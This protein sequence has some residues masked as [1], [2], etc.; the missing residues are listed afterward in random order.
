MLGDI[1]KGDVVGYP[2]G[3]FVH[4]A[5]VTDEQI[6]NERRPGKTKVRIFLVY[7]NQHLE[8][9]KSKLQEAPNEEQL[10]PEGV[11]TKLLIRSLDMRDPP[12]W[13]S[14]KV[15]IPL[16]QPLPE[17][18]QIARKVAKDKWRRVS[19]RSRLRRSSSR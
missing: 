18:I 1:S 2:I 12:V 19:R 14:R 15:G 11:T 10:I 17:N 6:P 9:N 16:Y 13:L 4:P 5:I 8:V 3:D 7:E